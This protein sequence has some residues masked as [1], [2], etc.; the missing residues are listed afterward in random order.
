[1][2]WLEHLEGGAWIEW[3]LT[4]HERSRAKN[5][6]C[7][8]DLLWYSMNITN[9]KILCVIRDFTPFGIV[10]RLWP[11]HSALYKCYSQHHVW[12][13]PVIT[14]EESRP[15]PRT[16]STCT[17]STLNETLFPDINDTKNT[18]IGRFFE[19]ILFERRTHCISSHPFVLL[20]IEAVIAWFDRRVKSLIQIGK[21]RLK[22]D[23]KTIQDIL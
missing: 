17:R 19:L 4:N 20:V 6:F 2:I 5:F 3:W 1:M 9:K 11:S 21:T 8:Q 15:D 23:L 16:M 14:N 18:I 12:T 7:D 10:E 22:N 13:I